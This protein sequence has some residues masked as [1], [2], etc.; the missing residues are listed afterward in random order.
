MKCLPVEELQGW[1]W[2][3]GWHYP[4]SLCNNSNPG[5]VRARHRNVNQ[6]KFPNA[7]AHAHVYKMLIWTLTVRMSNS[8][9]LG[10]FNHLR[11]K[12]FFTLG[13]AWK[14]ARGMALMGETQQ[15]ISVTLKAFILGSVTKCLFN[16]GKTT[17]EIILFGPANA[18][19]TIMSWQHVLMTAT[20]WHFVALLDSS[21]CRQEIEKRV[22]NKKLLFKKKRFF[23][24]RCLYL[25]VNRQETGERGWCNM[26]QRPPTDLYSLSHV[27]SHLALSNTAWLSYGGQM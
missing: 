14:I 21:Q 27:L 18:S 9:R 7:K 2:F 13:S 23:G 1:W 8:C 16:I 19:K 3:S 22:V 4:T 10:I 6:S 26:Q 11:R 20:F 25:T 15:S 12:C 24:H 5:S 17:Q